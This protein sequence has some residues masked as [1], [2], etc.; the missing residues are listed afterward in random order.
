[1]KRF[2]L[3]CLSLFLVAASAFAQVTVKG[4]VTSAEDSQ[5]LPGVSIVV[6]GTNHGTVTDIDG[7]YQIEAANG[8]VLQFSFVGYKTVEKKAANVVN[9]VMESD[10]IMMNEVV[11]LGYSSVKKA[12]LS[13]A[14]V[15]IS[16]D[17]L[18]DVTSSDV[19]QMLQGK[20]AGVQVSSSTGQPGSSASIRI[21]GTGSITASSDPVYV[22][23]GVMG[24]SFNPND[25]ESISIL[26]DA[27]ATGIYGAAAAGGVIVVTT[28]QGNKDGKPQVNV[29]TSVGMDQPLFGRYKK[30][31]SEELYY[32]QK[33][34]FPAALFKDQRPAS[35]LSQDF[36]YRDEYFNTGVTQD[37][38]ISLSGGSQKLG[39]YVS[40]DY[41]NQEGSL[42]GTDYER[43]SG[44]ANVNA[45]IT[46]W[47]DMN[48][49][50]NFDKDQRNNPYSWI[51]LDDAYNKLPWDNPYDVNTGEPLYVNSGTRSDNGKP[52]I[53]QYKWNALNSMQKDYN[54]DNGF[55][56]GAD[57]Q[58]AV[59]FTDWLTL[60]STVR[61]AHGTYKNTSFIDPT[62]Y[63]SSWTN[64]H[65]A[66][67]VGISSSIGTT[68][69]L[70][71]S[72]Q[73]G[74]HS[75]NAMLG[76]EWSRWK[77]EYTAADGTG[78]P[79]GVQ[80]L[81]ACVAQSVSG[82]EVPGASWAAFI[83]ASYDYAK[84]Y[85]LTAT[86]RTEASSIF[87]PEH[88]IGYFPSIAA[89]W[90]ISNEGFMKDV[91]KVSMLKLRASYGVTG[92]NGIPPYQYLS[93]VALSG[94]YQNIVSGQFTRLSNPELHW[95]TAN[96]A[97]VGIDLGL[98]NR[99]NM[100]LDLYNTDNTGLLLTVP[101]S[102]STGFFEVTQNAGSVRNQGIEY[103]IDAAIISTRDWHWNVGFNIGFNRNRV[104][105]LPN[106]T[107]FLQG[108]LQ[109]VQEGHNMFSW[110]M[111]EWAG[112]D[113]ANGD[114]L[115]YV[116]DGDGNYV[117]DAAGAKTTTNDYN[118]TNP[119]VVGRADA[120]FQGG[121]NTQVSW[122]GLSLSVNTFFNYGNLVYNG[123]RSSGD[124]DGA[125]LGHN[126]LS[127]DNGLGWSRWE[128]PGD[129]ATHPKTVYNGNKGSN[130]KSS[131]YLEDGSYFRLKNVTLSYDFATI[132]PKGYVNKLRLY[133]S[134]DNLLTAT[135]FSGMDPECSLG[136]NG[137]IPGNINDQYPVSRTIMF[138]LEVQF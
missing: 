51:V 115:W 49:R 75:F 117:L 125:Y 95:E 42:K 128:Y 119:H 105:S 14:V 85:F 60:Q 30:M 76:H 57:L 90:L 63:D 68:T 34:F 11:S 54:R 114:P 38:Y 4:T 87:A 120:I 134:G 8:A 41:F 91:D 25:V 10:A 32:Y 53:S 97:T 21:R 15:T 20:V 70:K 80:A 29:R 37:Y 129:N 73:W 136:G 24:G 83:Q 137:D 130:N 122:K 27:G 112:V 132:I 13:S 23:D 65:L 111:K 61:Y 118:A 35:L 84:R 9:V 124:S 99:I 126:A 36:S 40:F 101:Q 64:G 47:L 28:K 102:P 88:R 98:L 52:W 100:S 33:S 72:Y 44:R 110:Y 79:T 74:K 46:K 96:M 50:V 89:S 113:P 121:L 127:L 71:G 19:G 67:T 107:P 56:M 12:E 92:N 135:K 22:V 16:S 59:H 6:K 17:A 133:V 1:M 131:R 106:H 18:T 123:N 109:Y 66:N 116:V 81:N 82:Y 94:S 26:K 103:S 55:N 62:T 45:Q 78:M 5:G 138:G 77:N 31:N 69:I 93:T 86:F 48:V 104:T 58:L 108:G 43:F 3:I 7:K 39:Y 2:Q